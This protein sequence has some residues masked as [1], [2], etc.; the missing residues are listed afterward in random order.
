[1]AGINLKYRQ[2]KKILLDNG[3]KE[4]RKPK[5]DHHIFKRQPHEI[6]SIPMSCNGLIVQRLFR[7]FNIKR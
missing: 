6:I 5:S 2:I 7:E 3:F 4:V 1:M